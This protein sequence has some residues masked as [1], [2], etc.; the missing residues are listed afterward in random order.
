M[1]RVKSQHQ[2]IDTDDITTVIDSL[3]T[4]KPGNDEEST[5]ETEEQEPATTAE[6]ELDASGEEKKEDVK[7]FDLIVLQSLGLAEDDKDEELESFERNIV[8][9]AKPEDT[10]DSK[11]ILM[12]SQKKKQTRRLKK[13][14]KN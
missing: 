1:M 8:S 3:D 2:Q 7:G 5:L 9:T 13:I 6:V 12:R 11:R 10:K 4:S 14:L